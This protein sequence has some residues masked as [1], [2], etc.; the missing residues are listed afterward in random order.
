MQEIP[1]HDQ[2]LKIQK[3]QGGEIVRNLSSFQL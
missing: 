2:K 3:F 1:F